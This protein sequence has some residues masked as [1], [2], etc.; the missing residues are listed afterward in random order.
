MEQKLNFAALK[1]NLIDVINEFQLKLGYDQSSIRLYYPIESLNRLLDAD[2]SIEEM[3]E[4]LL[5]F[6]EWV[7]ES[8]GNIFCT[9][10]EARFCLKIPEQG[11]SFVY[12]ETKDNHFL[13]EFITKTECP[14]CNIADLVS[15]FQHYSHQVVCKEMNNHEFDYLIYFQDGYPD[16]YRY[17]IKF[18]CGHVIYHR[19]TPKDYAVLNF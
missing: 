8:L 1:K 14:N 18:E 3:Q 16:D 9:H 7:R 4:A 13:K 17:C 5:Q 10:E 11:V 15:V 12:H 19:F 2:L 6:S